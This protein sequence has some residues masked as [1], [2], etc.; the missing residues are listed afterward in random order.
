MSADANVQIRGIDAPAV[1]T[2]QRDHDEGEIQAVFGGG[3]DH[4]GD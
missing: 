2:A 1:R 4:T 3:G